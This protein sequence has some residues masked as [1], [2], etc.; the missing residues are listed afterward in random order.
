M[1][2]R[3]CSLLASGLTLFT[4]LVSSSPI[5]PHYL[6]AVD[7][8]KPVS[9]KQVQNDLGR[10]L[11]KGT[12]I[13]GP[14]NPAFAE[15]TE[16]WSTRSMPDDIQVV[17]EVA[18][19]SDVAKVVK[20]CYQNSLDFLAYTRGHGSS[21]TISKFRGIEINLSKLNGFT[22][23]P[24]KKSALFQGGVYA[25]LIIK[26][27]WNDG[28]IVRGLGRYQGQYGLISDNF[29]SLNVVLANGTE[30]IVSAK[31]NSDLFWAMKGAG[32]NFGIVTSAYIK[33][34]PRKAS[35]W[36]YHNYV[37]S[38]DKLE[39]VFGA[40]NK[41]QGKGQIPALM[42]V[43][44]G[45][46]S[47]EPS[48]SKT[49]AVII[50]SFAYDGPAADAEK[51]L[52]PFNAISAISST[53]GDVSY[54]ELLVAQQTDINS[55]SCSSQ[56]YVGSTA[57]LQTYNVSSQREIYNL[58]NKKIAENPGL[59]PGARV[60][61]EGYSTKATQAI[62]PNTS[63]YPH[64]DEYLLVFFAVAAPPQLEGFART[65]AD[66]TVGIWYA[67]QPGRRRATYVNYAV[68]NEPLESIYGYDGQL[69]RLRT[70]KSKYDPRN[71]FRWY[72]PI[73]TD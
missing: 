31:S 72:N 64:R 45:Q 17:V 12:L 43:N 66:K 25:D 13:F 41:F 36:H 28:Y 24:D 34:Y 8:S 3:F 63:S 49:E 4:R 53:K 46:F 22:I 14:S 38:Q 65:W 10:T 15:A 42:G 9:P 40:L 39:K 57:W 16:R 19:E 50:W 44:F 54:P 60:F 35:T 51:L 30:T 32:H 23:Q 6:R 61:F 67:S 71:K 7:V 56:P 58:F 70:L 68:G 33:I 5:V 59:A 69:S 62:D 48:I 21:S 37:W 52:T 26:K 55:A 18:Q 1:H 29:V 11:S 20:Y 47:I 2:L 27:L 73:A